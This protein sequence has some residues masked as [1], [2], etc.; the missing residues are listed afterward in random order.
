VL[1]IIGF[2]P[3]QVRPLQI[4]P[5]PAIEINFCIENKGLPASATSA[6][7]NC[8]FD[9]S[10]SIA[11]YGPRGFRVRDARHLVKASTN[12]R[13]IHPP[14]QTPLYPVN[15]GESGLTLP[16]RNGDDPIVMTWT[17]SSLS[18]R[19]PQEHRKCLAISGKRRKIDI[20]TINGARPSRSGARV[21][22]RLIIDH[23]LPLLSPFPRKKRLHAWLAN[24]AVV[25]T[26]TRCRALPS[27]TG[28]DRGED[29]TR[30]TASTVNA[31][32]QQPRRQHGEETVCREFVV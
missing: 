32:L 31:I 5:D 14:F 13:M 17:L 18:T 11:S 19:R 25:L 29:V 21:R 20:H 26:P 24:D 23:W 12:Y 2:R 6:V 10:A 22:R 1:Q 3:R 27:G 7:K 30:C 9:L 16:A 8:C 4:R 15:P 28:R